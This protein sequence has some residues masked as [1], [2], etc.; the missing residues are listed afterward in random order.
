MS[1]MLNQLLA[2][3]LVVC[4]LITAVLLPL[5]VVNMLHVGPRRHV[6]ANGSLTTG[7]WANDK[8]ELRNDSLSSCLINV[9]G[10]A[11]GVNAPDL[12][13]LIVVIND[14]DGVVAEVLYSLFNYIRIVI[15]SIAL[16]GALHAPFL[17]NLLWN[18]VVDDLL[19]F[20]HTLLEELS[21]V[22]G[23]WES[24]NQVALQRG[25]ITISSVYS[26]F[27]IANN[28]LIQIL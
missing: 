3:F 19:R 24:I 11:G 1:Q 23:A 10:I 5:R 25:I 12:T 2:T 14:W 16:F 21:L 27:K 22:N 28:N 6:G 4:I 26:N 17:H 15:W 9:V 8:H 18:V 20:A 7:L 13:N